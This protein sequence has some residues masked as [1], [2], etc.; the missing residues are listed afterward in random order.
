VVRR[1]AAVL[2]LAAAW[3]AWTILAPHAARPSEWIVVIGAA[4]VAMPLAGALSAT[5]VAAFE[6]DREI[7]VLLAVICGG[8]TVAATQADAPTVAG[9]LKVLAASALGALLAPLLE[10]PWQAALIAILVIG[11]DTYSVFRGPTKQ[12]LAQGDEVVS[13]F[14]VPLSS[15]GAYGAFGLGITDFMFLA[16]FVASARRFTLRPTVTVPLLVASFSA[17]LLLAKYFDHAVPALPL[18]S[19]AFLVPNIDRLRPSS[20][21]RRRGAGDGPATVANV[22]RNA[23]AGPDRHAR[24][25]EARDALWAVLDDLIAPDAVVAIV[26]AGNCDDVPLARIAERAARV[27]LLDVDATAAT[28]AIR[29][30]PDALRPRLRA[31]VVDATGG[32]AD[33]IVAAVVA[34]RIE[35]VPVQDWKPLG[36]PPYDVVVGDLLY[37]Q[38]L[39]PGLL[40]AGVPDER[41]GISLRTYGDATTGLV[42]SRLHASAP[43]GVVVHVNDPVA[44]WQDHEQPFTLAALLA[45]AELGADDALRLVATGN[46]PTGCDPR[47]AL[48]ALGI[49]VL[50]TAFWRWPFTA[51]VDYA[52]CAT[53]ARTPE[54]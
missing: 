44:W 42:V 30:Q 26:G 11:V 39:Y 21:P 40:D 45:R 53:V 34:G 32:I 33:R 38:L 29:R 51:G 18:L 49:T 9:L 37:S 8:F 12:I 22:R 41:I 6:H 24:W 7:L 28:A 14:T 48:A 4:C 2:I 19:L 25:S 27:D 23:N 20:E 46:R 43:A 50:E 16:L 52:V 10:R 54:R 47:D 35:P 17:S 1:A 3:C 5:V 13:W 15:L 31:L 36:E